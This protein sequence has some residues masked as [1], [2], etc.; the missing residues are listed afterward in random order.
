MA[1]IL[2]EWQIQHRADR[3]AAMGR[4]FEDGEVFYTLLLRRGEGLERQ[5]LCAEAWKER[6]ADETAE[7]PF[8]FWRTKFQPPTAAPP[9]ALPK[10]NA[11]TL[12]RGYLEGGRPE[13]AR[14]CYILALML[15]RKRLLRPIETREEEGAG[16]LLV[17]EHVKTGDTFVVRDPQLR[18]DQLT[19]VQAEVAD[20]MSPAHPVENAVTT[21]EESPEAEPP[22][23]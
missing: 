12:L 14:A 7:K 1:S 5:D 10:E 18:L 22:A 8:C 4:P 2:Q 9:D 21:P 20:L 16:R 23:A 6:G 13:H 11:E 17:Y 15:E 19:E 3:C